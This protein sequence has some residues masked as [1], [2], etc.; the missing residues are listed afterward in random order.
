MVTFPKKFSLLSTLTLN[1]GI[2]SV[3]CSFGLLKSQ[4]GLEHEI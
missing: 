3:K 2:L 1:I 4:D